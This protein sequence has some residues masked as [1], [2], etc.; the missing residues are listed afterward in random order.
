M[1]WLEGSVL[2]A[3]E[4]LGNHVAVDHNN[5]EDA[6]GNLSRLFTSEHNVSIVGAALKP[7]CRGS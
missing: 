3:V 1:R 4:M 2:F 5:S 7:G 6:E